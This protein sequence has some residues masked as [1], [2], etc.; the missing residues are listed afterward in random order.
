MMREIKFRAWDIN[1]GEMVDLN[2]CPQLVLR[3]SGKVTEGSTCPNIKLLQYTGL[4]DRNGVEVYEGDIIKAT[5]DVDNMCSGYGGTYEIGVFEV[6]WDD[7]GFMP[8]IE[9]PDAEFEVIGNIYE[10]PELG[11]NDE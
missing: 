4:K 1:M 3:L 11:E 5:T 10:N 9:L 2:A 6:M 7:Y 8:F